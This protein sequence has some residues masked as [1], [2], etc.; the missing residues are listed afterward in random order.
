MKYLISLF[1]VLGIGLLYTPQVFASSGFIAIPNE[2]GSSGT[3]YAGLLW[4][5]N[6]YTQGP[7]MDPSHYS[8]CSGV[9]SNYLTGVLYNY[10][11]NSVAATGMNSNISCDGYFV[12]QNGNIGNNFQDNTP[13]YA[14]ITDVNTGESWTTPCFEDIGNDNQLVPCPGIDSPPVLQLLTNT[15]IQQGGTYTA[16]DSFTDPDATS[17]TATV[18]YGDGSG[19]QP[20]TLSGTNFTLSHQYNT[21][22][23]YYVNVTVT[24]NQGQTAAVSALIKVAGSGTITIPNQWAG[25]GSTN[26]GLLWTPNGYTASPAIDPYHYWP[27]NQSRTGTDGLI[28]ALYNRATNTLVTTTPKTYMGCDGYMIEQDTSLSSGTIGADFQDNTPYYFIITDSNTGQTWKSPC[29]EDTGDDNQLV[30]CPANFSISGTVFT[31]SNHNGV[32]DNGEQDY[33]NATVTVSQ[34]NQIVASTTTGSNGSYSFPSLAAGPYSAAITLP[35]GYTATTANPINVSLTENTTE[36]FGIIPNAPSIASITLNSNPVTINTTLHASSSFTDP[37]TN[38]TDSASWN[39]GDTHTSIGTVIENKGSGSVSNSHTYNSLGSDTI[40]LTVTDNI[41]L[42]D[43]LQEVVAVIPSG[44]LRGGNLAGVNY[45]GANLS[46]QNI[47]N[48]NIQNAIFNNANLTNANFTS[49][50]AQGASFIQADLA[51]AN[52]TEADFQNVNFSSANLT[53]ADFQGDNVKGS[54]MSEANLTNANLSGGNFQSINFTNANLAGVNLNTSNLKGSTVT[55]VTWSNTTCPN[56]TNS[57]KDNNTCVGQGG[58][59]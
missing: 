23:T 59:L 50:N 35:S 6:N 9:S 46:G 47:S 16:N 53:S 8:T 44:G 3:I 34:N 4:T 14:T 22:G 5:P 18:N 15:N 19:A 24:D 36:N 56:G 41:R 20:L 43:I 39:W 12:I 51:G 21:Q 26:A 10:N 40:T 27:C 37:I 32:Q 11:N 58:G 55:G 57:N 49:D 31:D 13:Y 25:S 1:I 38:Y 7:Y 48:G 2:F 54:K 30:T 52:L 17:W 45:S 29:F 28:G 33:N 42:S